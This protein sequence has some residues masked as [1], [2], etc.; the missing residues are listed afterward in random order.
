MPKNYRFRAKPDPGRK[1][2]HLETPHNRVLIYTFKKPDSPPKIWI[3]E[4]RKIWDIKNL[5]F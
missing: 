5:S 3:P 1:I 2:L 4:S